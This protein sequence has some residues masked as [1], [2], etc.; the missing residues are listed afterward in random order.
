MNFTS[1]RKE[2]EMKEGTPQKNAH[3]VSPF[4]PIAV[5]FGEEEA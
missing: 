1:I 2:K 5:T 3:Y 4:I